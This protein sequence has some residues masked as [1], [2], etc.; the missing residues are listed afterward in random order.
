[1]TDST[2]VEHSATLWSWN[3]SADLAVINVADADSKSWAWFVTDSD[4][5]QVGEKVYV[6][7]NPLDVEGT[8]TDGMLSAVRKNGALFQISAPLDMATQEAPYLT[9]TD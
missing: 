4:W 3:P 5:E 6:Y 9:S 1:M 7:G 8:F 2:G